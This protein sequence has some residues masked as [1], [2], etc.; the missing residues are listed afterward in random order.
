MPNLFLGFPVARAKIADMISTQAPPLLH[1]SDHEDGGDDEVDATGLEGAGGITL[2]LDDIYFNTILQAKNCFPTTIVTGAVV[3]EAANGLELISGTANGSS[4]TI[5]KHINPSHALLTWAKE[6]IVTFNVEMDASSWGNNEIW[7]ISGTKDTYQ[8]IGFKVTSSRLRATV[9][10]GTETDLDITGGENTG[11]VY[12]AHSLRFHFEPLVRARFYVDGSLR[13]T[14][15]DNL[16]TGT[17]NARRIFSFYLKTIA[18]SSQAK[19]NFSSFQF[20]Q[21]A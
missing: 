11:W 8:H 17:S 10:N 6:R 1:A 20:W 13:G 3:N 15:T 9:A 19:L 16:P 2:P 5:Y 12:G 7:I 4:V 18:D 14:I 21:A